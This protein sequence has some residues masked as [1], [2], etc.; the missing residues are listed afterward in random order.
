VVTVVPT[1][2]CTSA[3]FTTTRMPPGASVK[4]YFAPARATR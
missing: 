2:T 3:P 1:G 4:V